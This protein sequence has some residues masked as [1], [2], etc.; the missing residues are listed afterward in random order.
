MANQIK[1]LTVEDYDEIIR[2]WLLSGLPFKPE[3]RDSKKLMSKE[4]DN[5]NV[6]FY[7]M[8]E[9]SQLIGVCIANYDGRRGWINRL[10][11]DP[12]YRGANLGIKLIEYCEQFLYSIGA[13]VIC[14]L[15]EDINY[16]S[17]ATFQKADYVCENEIKYFAKRPHKDM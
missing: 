3:G 17:V 5:D 10:A 13:K 11:I 15:I 8:Y 12:D 16:P 6:A 1:R 2:I 14:T 9:N 4:M 7:G